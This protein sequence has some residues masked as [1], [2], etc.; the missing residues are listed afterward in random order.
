ML[1]QIELFIS[2]SL[3]VGLL[4]DQSISDWQIEIGENCLK[5][6]SLDQ[7]RRKIPDFFFL[8]IGGVVHFLKN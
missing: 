5:T 8:K 7:P 3:N 1:S 2:F 6:K 4:M